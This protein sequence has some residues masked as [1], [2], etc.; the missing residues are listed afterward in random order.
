M[1]AKSSQ[2]N[3]TSKQLSEALKRFSRSVEL[4]D[5]YLRGFYGLKLVSAVSAPVDSAYLLTIYKITRQLLKEPQ[6]TAKQSDDDGLSL[7]DTATLRQ[8]DELATKKLA[9]ITRRFSAGE[10]GWQGYDEAEIT[11]AKALLDNDSDATI[12]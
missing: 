10:K 3:E 4:C 5:D 8:L 6:K 2:Q 11:A 9:E 1:A 7:P 12:R